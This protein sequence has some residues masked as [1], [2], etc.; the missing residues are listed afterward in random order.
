V[1][2][3]VFE[4]RHAKVVIVHFGDEMRLARE[5]DAAALKLSDGEL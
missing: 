1:T 4:E 3:G 5:G 2:V